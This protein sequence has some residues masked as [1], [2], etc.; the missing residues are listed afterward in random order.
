MR[1]TFKGYLIESTK[2]KADMHDIIIPGITFQYHTKLNQVIWDG[3]KLKPSVRAAMKRVAG[4]FIKFLDMPGIEVTDITFTGSLANFNYTQYSDVDIHLIINKDS[5]FLNSKGLDLAEILKK[6]KTLYNLQHT[7]TIKGFPAELYVQTHDEK[8]NATG[9]YSVKKNIW[10]NKPPRSPDVACKVDSYAVARKAADLK[11]R[12]NHVIKER[13][14]NLDTLTNLK[15]RVVNSRKIGL[16]KGGELSCENIAYKHL[17][18]IGYIDKLVKYI[19]SVV[20]TDL[21]LK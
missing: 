5:K 20:D 11:E 14:T 2:P 17:R 21:T 4:D 12:I 19:N 16:D 1:T 15:N 13:V 18:A 10:I 7:I 6:A 9:I 8:V 3:M